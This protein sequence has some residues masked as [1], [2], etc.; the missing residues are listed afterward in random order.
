MF[1]NEFNFKKCHF[2]YFAFYCKYIR[3]GSAPFLDVFITKT[4]NRYNCEYIVNKTYARINTITNFKSGDID[5]WTISIVNP[6]YINNTLINGGVYFTISSDTNKEYLYQ[7][8]KNE[9]SNTPLK[10][11]SALERIYTLL[12]LY[13][14]RNN[15]YIFEHDKLLDLKKYFKR[16]LNNNFNKEYSNC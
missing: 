12:D 2:V 13:E 3:E 8:L 7:R 6:F 15:Q 11:M 1:M 10:Y 5:V 9:R 14:D 4:N 16:Y